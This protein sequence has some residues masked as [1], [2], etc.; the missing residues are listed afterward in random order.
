MPTNLSCQVW[1]HIMTSPGDASIVRHKIMVPT[2]TEAGPG[3]QCFLSL[4][5][6]LLRSLRLIYINISRGA[7]KGG[8]AH[9]PV[10]PPPYEMR[11]PCDGGGPKAR[12]RHCV[13]A[14]PKAGRKPVFVI[15]DPLS[16]ESVLFLF[17]YF[18]FLKWA[19]WEIKWPKSVEF[20]SFGYRLG[21]A[22][23]EMEGP[24]LRSC[25]PPLTK[26]L[27]APL[28][29]RVRRF[30]SLF[31]LVIHLQFISGAPEFEQ[32]KRRERDADQNTNQIY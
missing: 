12:L 11:G 21:W 25:P 15:S 16:F 26:I 29:I 24:P 27:C 4:G 31:A 9:G 19:P 6:G 2:C 5:V 10:P 7:H 30:H 23:S 18:F 13:P 14:G 32:S 20:S 3:S 1:K 22:P 8:G 28:N 17:I